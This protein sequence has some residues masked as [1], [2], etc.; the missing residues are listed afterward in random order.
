MSVHQDIKEKVF[1]NLSLLLS[2]C[3]SVSIFV[4]I[5]YT[6]NLVVIIIFFTADRKKLFGYISTVVNDSGYHEEIRLCNTC[7]DK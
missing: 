1:F 4:I 3:S 2:H 5:T 6:I 7:N